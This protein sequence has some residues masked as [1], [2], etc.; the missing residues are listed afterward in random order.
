LA[1]ELI[2]SGWSL[3]S[4]QRQ[5]VLSR[6]YRLS[7]RI[8]PENQSSD[9]GNRWLWRQSRQRLDAETVRD[10]LLAA[11]GVLDRA[12]RGEHPFP[13]K[14]QWNFTQHAPFEA[15]YDS[16]RRSVYLMQQRLK[17]HPLLALF[18]G[19][20]PNASTAQRLPTTTP[21][22]ALFFMN[23][24]Q[25]HDLASQFAERVIRESADDSRRLDQAFGLLYCRLPTDIE[26]AAVR[27]HLA[28]VRAKVRASGI[29][30]D[31][32]ETRHCWNSLAR[33]LLCANEF[34]YVD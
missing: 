16:N 7:S 24:P 26:R 17:R 19:P 14:D 34:I 29:T 32:E 27:E 28:R 2:E 20:D 33:V 22:Q 30:L 31:A 11:A 3:K 10:A 21:L 4:I 25:V 12:Q 23:D 13:A 9:P 8:N 18:D 15:V 1:R 6:T 5:I